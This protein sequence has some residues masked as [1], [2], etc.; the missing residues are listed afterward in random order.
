MQ[1]SI[2]ATATICV[3]NYTNTFSFNPQESYKADIIL[4][5]TDDE[6]GSRG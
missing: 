5:C 3:K 4:H 6:T 1:V 2:I